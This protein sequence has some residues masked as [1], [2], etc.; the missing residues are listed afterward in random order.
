MLRLKLHRQIL[1][2]IA[3]AAF[4]GAILNAKFASFDT[5]VFRF[6]GVLFLNALKRIIVPLIMS[7]I[8]VAIAGIGSSGALGRLGG[9]TLLSID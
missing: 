6:I 1:I 4:I 9:L 2:A 3:L 7:S 8:I 5:V